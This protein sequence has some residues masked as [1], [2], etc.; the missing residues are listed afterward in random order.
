MLKLF[1]NANIYLSAA[2]SPM[3]GSALV[4]EI[5]KRKNIK[6]FATLQVLKEAEKN[7]RLKEKVQVLIR[8]YEILKFLNPKIIKINKEKAKIKFAKIIDEKDALVLAGAKKV[9]IDYLITIDKKHFL[10]GKF[11]QPNYLLKF[12]PLAS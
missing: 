5:T 3:G 11:N 6:V 1:L 10:P 4:I 12:S 2:R 7:L 8:H 9:R